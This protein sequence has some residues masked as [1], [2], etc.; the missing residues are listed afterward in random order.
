MYFT[1]RIIYD[2]KDNFFLCKNVDLLDL[3]VVKN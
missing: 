3:L 2:V 1:N